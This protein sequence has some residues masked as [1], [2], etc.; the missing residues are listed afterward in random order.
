MDKQR[1]T[2]NIFEEV[3]NL[4]LPIGEYVIVGSGPMAARE[5]RDFKD[6]DIL[7][8]EK[9][10]D[11]LIKKDWKV[12]EIEG[13]G[14]KF[15]VLKK[16]IFEVNTTLWHGDYKPNTE[17]LIKKAEII[18]GM[19]FLPLPELIKFKTALGR[20]KDQKDIELINNY[21]KKISDEKD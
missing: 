9:L 17:D 1:K 2:M 8:S 10:Y 20:E 7:V 13:V 21:L 14:G 3:R 4:N 6:I 19:P 12:V 16:G 15:K 18:C 11:E 5:I